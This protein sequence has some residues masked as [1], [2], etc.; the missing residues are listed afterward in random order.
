MNE[1]QRRIAPPLAQAF[2]VCREIFEDCR[3]HDF[4]LIAPFSGLQAPAFPAAT[5]LS[6]YAAL[7]CGHGS[8][9]LTLQLR[10]GD[11][12]PQWAW[13]CPKPIR[14]DN[15]LVQH[16]FTLYDVVLEFPRP[17]RYDLVLLANGSEV[18]RHALHVR[19]PDQR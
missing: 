17:G 4:M 9:A 11:D 12:Q 3:S 1:S 6:I 15:P 5:R 7:T 8:Y 16:Q 10:D 19:A 18:A 13:D 14:L 2:V